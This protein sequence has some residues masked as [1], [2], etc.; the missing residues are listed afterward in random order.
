MIQEH[1][2]P[3][4]VL[5]LLGVALTSMFFL[6]AFAT[7]NSNFSK[8]ENPFPDTFSPEKIMASLDNVS[9]SYS[10]F[11][12]DMSTP[13][14]QS[15][16][17]AQDNVHYI[18]DNSDEQILSLTGLSSLAQVPQDAQASNGHVAGASTQV[19][20]SKYYPAPMSGADSLFTLILGR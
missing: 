2:T 9:N 17:I 12:A 20:Y 4:R 16:A 3:E 7:T 13:M 1:E 14:V 10:K 5:S 19:V 8:A 15:L 11:I 18:I 6:F